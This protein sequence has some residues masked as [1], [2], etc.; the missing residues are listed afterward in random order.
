[1]CGMFRWQLQ[2]RQASTRIHRIYSQVLHSPLA[3]SLLVTHQL[4]EDLLVIC[5]RSRS[6]EGDFDPKNPWQVLLPS[7]RNGGGA[8]DL[9]LSCSFE[10]L[11]GS[12]L[13]FPQI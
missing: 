4:H 8:V 13:K 3:R 2:T 11:N 6:A 12:P 7:V 5:I 1:M 9:L 10:D